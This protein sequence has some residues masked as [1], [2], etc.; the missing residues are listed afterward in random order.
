MNK[1]RLLELAGITLTEA[2]K[3]T[4][5]QYEVAI[6]TIAKWLVQISMQDADD[7]DEID[8]LI[9]N[10]TGDMQQDI[11]DAVRNITGR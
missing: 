3:V 2:E 7:E 4:D 8:D 11:A 1:Q 9:D 6:I 10:Y 5:E